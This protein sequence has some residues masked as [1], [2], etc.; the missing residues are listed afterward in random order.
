M[1][2]EV[3]DLRWYIAV[4][5]ELHFARAAKSLNIA[6]T[7]LSATVIELETTLGYSLFVPGASPTQ[8]TERGAEFLVEAHR[9]VAEDAERVAAEA[10]QRAEPTFTIGYTEGVT[11]T[12]WTR[13]WAE[14]VP[15][16]ELQ[17]ISTTTDTQ[18]SPLADGSA[19]VC[20][21]RLPVARDGLSVISLYEEQPVVVVPKDHPIA[22]YDRV[23]VTDLADEHLIQDADLVPEWASV[24][25][26]I[27]DGTRLAPLEADSNAQLLEYVA[28]G[29]GIV[30]VPQSIARLHSRKDLVYRPV[31]GVAP[32][33]IAIV[34]PTDRTTELVEEFVGI[35]RGRSARSSRGATAPAAQ[36]RKKVVPKKKPQ[37]T[38]KGRKGSAPSKRGKRS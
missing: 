5:E 4:A 12:K 30:V 10:A 29:L 21:V 33:P 38:A 3:R 11:L 23:P 31:D 19:D 26:E 28:A 37:P 15:G 24:A 34:W 9:I 27:A 32:S 1:N 35:V 18:L 13:I 20:F 16:V 25:T 6:R 2:F 17:L 22:A 14:R 8:L 7:R 36:P